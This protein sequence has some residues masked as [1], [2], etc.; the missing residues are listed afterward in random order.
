MKRPTPRLL[1]VIR[2]QKLTPHMQR[3]VLGG[4][5]LEDFPL[6]RES[7]NFKL[8]L[9][10]SGQE[11]V[12]L[13][14]SGEKPLVRTYTI[15]SFDP[16]KQEISVDFMLHE[17]PGPASSW[18]IQAQPGDRVGFA[19]PG[20]AKFVDFE[21]D[22]FFF[23]GD[24]SALPAIA[25]NIER[26]PENARGYAVLEILDEAD[27]QDLP[28]PEA[29]EVHWVINPHPTRANR[30]LLD[31]AMDKAWLE[32]SPSVWIAGEGNMVKPLRRY[33]KQERQVDPDRL[34][35]SPY[36]QQ[37]L[38]EDAHQAQKRKAG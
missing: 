31:A 27:K 19:G 26:L 16:V 2:S 32:G 6:D 33:M 1:T 37:G 4:P 7:A 17:D 20:P 28:F 38:T 25:A 5:G 8:I 14:G 11:E 21:A 13:D 34:Y 12:N 23:V 29:V 35:A 36:W 22:W 9:P 18:A 30:L 24:M 10:R 15:R 3:I